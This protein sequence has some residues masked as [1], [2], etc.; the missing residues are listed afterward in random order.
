MAGG[1]INLGCIHAPWMQHP[2][3]KKNSFFF[4]SLKNEIFYFFTSSWWRNGVIWQRKR[5][6]HAPFRL[7]VTLPCTKP[8]LYFHPLLHLP[9]P[10]LRNTSNQIRDGSSY[11]TDPSVTTDDGSDVY[12]GI[13]LL[14][15]QNL[16]RASPWRF[17]GV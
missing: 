1:W 14:L 11:V 17:R 10:F 12:A 16:S 15:T 2:S 9:F 7:A 3:H 8:C 4:L 13:L 6:A 5:R